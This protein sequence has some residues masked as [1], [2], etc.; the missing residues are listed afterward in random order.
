[1]KTKEEREAYDRG[2]N[3]G[4]ASKTEQIER[5][6]PPAGLTGGAVHKTIRRM[7]MDDDLFVR[8]CVLVR[9]AGL[10]EGGYDPVSSGKRLREFLA[11]AGAPKSE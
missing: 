2:F 9:A 6:R 7:L 5:G 3:D 10:S 11:G 1:M 4:V 8:L